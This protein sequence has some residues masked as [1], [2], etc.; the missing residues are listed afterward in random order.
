MRAGLP[1]SAVYLT[2]NDR[3]SRLEGVESFAFF[4][5]SFRKLSCRKMDAFKTCW[6]KKVTQV[7]LPLISLTQT[8]AVTGWRRLT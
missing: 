8:L 3:S 6:D 7:C 1:K 5:F 4:L 2:V